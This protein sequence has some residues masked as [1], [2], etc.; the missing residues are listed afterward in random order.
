MGRRE[1]VVI[2]V[3]AT[4][5]GH[6]RP[7]D[8]WLNRGRR[9]FSAKADRVL[10]AEELI[11]LDAVN[12]VRAVGIIYG[13]L[14]DIEEGTGRVSIEAKPVEDSELIG[15]RIRRSE[16]RNPVAYVNDIEVLAE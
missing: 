12:R 9:W 11:V 10:N 16:S 2:R 7:F 6:E 4:D 3:N 1:I 8:W 13:V 5:F 15:K 14:K